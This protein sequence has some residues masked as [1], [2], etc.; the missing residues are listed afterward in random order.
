MPARPQQ[1]AAPEGCGKDG[2]SAIEGGRSLQSLVRVSHG[3]A[4]LAHGGKAM[5]ADT[6]GVI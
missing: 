5:P 4:R 1:A 6:I 3:C 2:K